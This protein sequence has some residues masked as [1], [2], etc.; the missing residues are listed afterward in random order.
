M[1]KAMRY[2]LSGLPRHTPA[3]LLPWPRWAQSNSDPPFLT[4]HLVISPSYHSTFTVQ[5]KP[6]HCSPPTLTTPQQSSPQH[7]SA[8][9]VTTPNQA[10]PSCTPPYHKWK[11]YKQNHLPPSLTIFQWLLSTSL[12]RKIFSLSHPLACLL[13]WCYIKQGSLPQLIC[14]C[15]N[16][17]FFTP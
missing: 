17:L 10:Q 12:T 4:Q 2:V 8:A 6:R 11:W 1:F 13:L 7:A 3:V 15:L 14:S 5:P 9:A 16:T